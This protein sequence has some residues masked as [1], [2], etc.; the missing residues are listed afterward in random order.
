MKIKITAY[1]TIIPLILFSGHLFA[2]NVVYT[3]GDHVDTWDPILPE[4]DGNWYNTKCTPTPEIGPDAGW[5]NPHKATQFG[6][7][8][9]PWQNQQPAIFSAEWINAWGNIDSIS[10]GGPG[11]HN[12]TKYSTEVTGEG[13]FVL[14]LLADNCSWI[15]LDGTLVGYQNTNNTHPPLQYPVAL[16]GTHT[17][18]FV[19]FDGG[20]S[21]G[22]M[23]RL[24]TNTGTVFEDSDNDGL[25]NTQEVLH[26]TDPFN[27]DSDGDGMNDG[28]EVA[29]GTDPTVFD[30]FVFD[31]DD[32]GLTDSEDACVNS[33][34]STT[35]VI[36]G[37]DS[38]VVNT[39]NAVGCN[40][41]DE[42]ALTCSG[43]FKNHG[44]FVS[45]VAHKSTELRKAGLI[46]NKERSALVNAAAK[47]K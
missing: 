34:I 26:H 37:V 31:A 45:C 16:N 8:V 6:F 42:L 36:N 19:I 29:G 21:A 18:E 39:F 15:Y 30:V 23:Y 5:I 38:G 13:E 20:G 22:G 25:S 35:V 14:D 12:W 9:H 32:D 28:D 17:L 27:P 24:E 40:I 1:L 44:Q 43:E 33:I 41:A 7:T 10:S 3:S 47:S 11:G 4:Y 46:N 2:Q